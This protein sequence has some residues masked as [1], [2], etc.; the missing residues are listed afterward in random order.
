MVFFVLKILLLS[1]GL[2]RRQ[3]DLLDFVVVVVVVALLVL[4]ED[5]FSVVIFGGED[6]VANFRMRFVFRLL[7]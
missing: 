2:Y 1:F 6:L 4:F 3:L 7:H 5:W